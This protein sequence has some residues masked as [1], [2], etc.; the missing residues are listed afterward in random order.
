[1]AIVTISR[2]SMSAG[3]A[4]ADCVSAVLRA[5]CIG[6]EV[7]VEKAA[8]TLG[9]SH[10]FL[11]QKLDKSPNLWERLTSERRAYVVAVEA[12][13]AEQAVKGELVYH[14]HA[15][16]LLVRGLPGVLRV[17]LIAPLA[18]RVR[19]VMQRHAM[20]RESA[21]AYIRQ[22]DADRIR[23][24]Q[25]IYGVDWRD[26]E[27]YDL[28]VNL[29]ALS[30]E[31]ACALVVEAS[32]RPEFAITEEVKARLQDHLLTCRVKVALAKHPATRGLDLQ[33]AVARGVATVAGEVPMPS[34]LTHVSNRTEVELV[35]VVKGVAGVTGVEL[36]VTQ[37]DTF[38][39]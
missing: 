13:L 36:H 31:S 18:Q 6:R 14:G 16:H 15:G 9:V 17:R 35:Q 25:F 37:V 5:P 2:G 8:A 21:E 32:R 27:L 33:V 10:E 19:T 30:L 28:V 3:Q 38:Q 29:D 34:M 12:A 11:E 7:L 23:W 26:P 1:V 22:V 39:H 20:R 4:L 24:T